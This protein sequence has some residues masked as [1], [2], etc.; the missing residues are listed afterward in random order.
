VKKIQKKVCQI[1]VVIWE[2]IVDLSVENNIPIT[3]TTKAGQTYTGIVQKPFELCHVGGSGG[4][5]LFLSKKGNESESHACIPYGSIDSISFETP[6]G[7]LDD[8]IDNLN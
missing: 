5:G 3:V 4:M 7:M 1:P 8:L 2:N 6:S